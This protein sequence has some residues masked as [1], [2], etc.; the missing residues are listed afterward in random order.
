MEK[1]RRLQNPFQTKCNLMNWDKDMPIK[2][3]TMKKTNLYQENSDLRA[4]KKIVCV[5]NDL[6]NFD[7]MECRKMGVQKKPNNIENNILRKNLKGHH[8]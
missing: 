8:S 5:R 1:M 7:P 6:E 4:D 3:T 2:I